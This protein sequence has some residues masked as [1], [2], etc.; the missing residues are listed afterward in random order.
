M[1]K[2]YHYLYSS[3]TC[4]YLHQYLQRSSRPLKL[5]KLSPWSVVLGIALLSSLLSRLTLGLLQP[6]V[7]ASKGPVV[8]YSIDISKP[9]KDRILDSG[10]LEKFLQENI[11][12]EGK[13][14]QLGDNIKVIRDGKSL[15]VLIEYV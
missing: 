14:G 3:Q 13:T 12:V 5:L 1:I 7:P 8:K 4:R 9:A 6:K 11:K 10:T 15:I 2:P